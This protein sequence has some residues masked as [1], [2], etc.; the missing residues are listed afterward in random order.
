MKGRI[1]LSSRSGLLTH[2]HCY[3]HALTQEVTVFFAKMFTDSVL[4]YY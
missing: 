3:V 4:N 2:L 1:V